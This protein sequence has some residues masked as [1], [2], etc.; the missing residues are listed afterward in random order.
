MSGVATVRCPIPLEE[1][2]PSSG[3]LRTAVTLPPAAYTSQEFFEFEAR[4]VFLKE[5]VC[6]GREEEIPNPGDYFSVTVVNEPLVVVR[7]RDGSINV[8]SA[9]CRHRGM[10]LTEDSGNC[11]RVLQ[12][13]YHG[14]TY[15]L[16]GDLLAAPEMTRSEDFDK[17]TIALYRLRVELWNGFIF[18]NFDQ[19]ADPLAPRLKRAE[20]V[21]RNYRLGEL[22]YVVPSSESGGPGAATYEM[23]SNWKAWFENFECYHCSHLHLGFHDCLP[24]SGQLPPLWDGSEDGVLVLQVKARHID[25]GFTESW[26]CRFPPIDTLTEQER[27]HAT[28]VII[29][30]TLIFSAAV[31]DNVHYWISLPNDA[32]SITAKVGW[33]YP[34]S[35]VA[36]PEFENEFRQELET[37]STLMAQDAYAVAGVS[38]GMGSR[39]APRGRL[40]P[41][42]PQ[43]WQFYRWL[44]ERYRRAAG[45]G[46]ELSFASGRA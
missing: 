38:K 45:D 12:C 10:V 25:P 15:G 28:W 35:T 1:F 31:P 13:P 44:V 24:T 20:W 23:A 3:A 36:L 17:S 41:L 6:L 21:L 39:F 19:N 26:H 40:S 8:L 42:E 16:Q 30:P 2:E 22:Q 46:S 32:T 18:A 9:V 14:W 37:L 11:G 33:L 4:A 34:Q 43:L 7:D 29:A 5:W 27:S